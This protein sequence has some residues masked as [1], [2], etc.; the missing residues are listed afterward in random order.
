MPVHHYKIN[1]GSCFIHR[2][3]LLFFRNNSC[4]HYI[5]IYIC[6]G[7]R[8]SGESRR[9]VQYKH[10]LKRIRI[11][12]NKFCGNGRNSD[13][14]DQNTV[15]RIGTTVLCNDYSITSGFRWGKGGIGCTIDW[16]SANTADPLIRCSRC[17]GSN[18]I[19]M[20][21]NACI[22]R[23]DYNSHSCRLNTLP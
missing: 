3:T 21:G 22:N 14:I 23:I 5:S 8:C 13:G 4:L 6:N 7:I 2:E 11:Y 20:R 16:L 1:S 10:Q 19:P 12:L 15:T 18:G 17:N 9:A